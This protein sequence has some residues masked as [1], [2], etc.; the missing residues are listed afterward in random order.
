VLGVRWFAAVSYTELIPLLI[1]SGKEL[2]QENDA[3]R[4][5]IQ[6]LKAAIR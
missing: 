6:D 1:E 2:K 5:E 3:L 4:R